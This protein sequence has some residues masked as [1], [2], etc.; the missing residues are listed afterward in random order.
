MNERL[1]NS[2]S[3][4]LRKAVEQPV[5]WYTWSDEAFQIAKREDKPILVDVGASWCHWCNVMD[6]NTYS[7]P[8]IAKIINENFIPIKV[9]RDEMPDVD[10]VLQNAVM[11]ITGESGWPLTVF[12]TP[13]KKVFFGGTYFP[14]E[15]MYG[16][17]GFRKVLLEIMRVWREER[18][19]I[20]SGSLSLSDIR[21]VYKSV[22]SL[23]R[24]LLDDAFSYI[25]S[26]YDIEY[27]GLGYGAKFP[28]TMVDLLFLNYSAVKGDDL[29]KKLGSFTLKKM[30]YGGIFDQVGGGFHR[31]T[32][33][34]EWKLPHFEK[35]LIDNSELIYD[36][37]NYYI[38]TLDVEILDGLKNS[39][40]FVIR[41]LYIK[42]S[43]FAN[44]IDAD[45]EG[46]EGKYYTWTEN[47]LREALGKDFDFAL[48]IFDLD[49]TVDVEGRKVLL[50]KYGLRDLVKLLKLGEE[51]VLNK[52]NE[53]RGKLLHY[54]E[55]NR[56]MPYRDDSVYTYTNAKIAEALLYS[57][58]ILGKGIDEARWVVDKIMSNRGIISRRLGGGKDGLLEDY[59]SSLL[60][61]ISAYEVL[62]D[63]KYYDAAIDLGRKVISEFKPE[64]FMDT[65]NE[66]SSS[67]YLRGLLKLSLLSDEFKV[68]EERIR[69]ITPTLTN[70]NAQFIAGII[71]SVSSY[72]NGL[73]H[74]VVVDEKDGLA[75]KLHRV[76]LTTYYPFKVVER[77]DDSRKDYVSSVIRAMLRYNAGK[78]RAYVCIGNTC[79][80]P[81]SDE[82][83]IKQLL[84]TKL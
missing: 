34:R 15:D 2:N 36:Y 53:V 6:E 61:I 72:V 66:S 79:S 40:D 26:Y 39:V 5:N 51:E 12:M 54:R 59:T 69:S 23:G 9:D 17:I 57:S 25:T 33:D 16:R 1:S 46:I 24:N 48:K 35:L 27:G 31:Y 60:S 68:D 49:D 81:V 47:E 80:M 78:S 4:Y 29:G 28:H 77:V 83:S 13:D 3:G 62:C 50:R 8:E 71:N 67:M 38:A 65:P 21:V 82:S 63:P 41:E 84:K 73:A 19:K 7:N 64:N 52:V 44:S 58:V 43:G 32:V 42:D 22:D 74:V 37:F 75:E 76:A 10:R 55:K 30:Y 45:S 70:E 20:E 18:E 11:A 56:K 14:P